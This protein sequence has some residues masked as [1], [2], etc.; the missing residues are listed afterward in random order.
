MITGE[1]VNQ[2][3][4][5]IM[6]H[7]GEEIKIE[8]VARHCNFSK[9]HFCRIFKEETGESVYAFIKRVRLEQSAFR[10]KVERDRTIT[11]IGYEYGYSPSNYSSVFKEYHN[12]S[13]AEFRKNIARHSMQHPFYPDIMNEIESFEE[14]DQKITIEYMEDQFVIYERRIG[15]YQNLG[16][17]WEE[18]LEKYKDYMT[19]QTLLL[20]STFDDVSITDV[21]GCLYDIC[22]TVARS[23]PLKNTNII[24]GGRFAV[25]HFKGFPQQ[26]YAAYQTMFNVWFPKSK[27]RIDK[28]YGF[29]CYREIDCETM[30]MVLDL[31]IPIE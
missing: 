21:D 26:I 10:L 4:N 12:T 9:F 24:P 14:C 15:N 6:E 20:E 5:Y 31:Y 28:R 22:M 27:Y 17:N 2:A 18:F 16:Q 3:I 30:H 29:D 1:I 11:D 13:P 25:Y 23:C 19:D 8:D 7:I